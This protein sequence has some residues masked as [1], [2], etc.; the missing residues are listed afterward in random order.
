MNIAPKF[1]QGIE[2]KPGKY[3]IKIDKKGY[4]TIDKWVTLK[5]GE[6][7]NLKMDMRK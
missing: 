7:L 5:A 4:Q 2:L 6:D 1:K 3:H